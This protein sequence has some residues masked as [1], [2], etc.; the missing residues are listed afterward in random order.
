VWHLVDAGATRRKIAQLGG[1][2][3]LVGIA[4]EIVC[5]GLGTYE[6]YGPHPFRVL[7]F[8]LWIA[9]G[10]AVIGLVSGIIAA[11][12]RPLLSGPAVW[13]YLPLVPVTMTMIHF[14][15]GFLAVD[16]INA[17]NP[18]TWLLYL[19]ATAAMALATTVAMAALKLV[20]SQ[21]GT[22]AEKPASLADS[23][24]GAVAG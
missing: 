17:P 6:Y 10:S 8:P 12:V 5:I 21:A 2:L 22:A 15:T 3:V 4:T 7:S 20:P 23:G 11:R 16:A 13:A 18:P 14:G 19:S 24:A 9:V 1:V